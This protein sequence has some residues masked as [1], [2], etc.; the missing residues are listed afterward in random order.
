VIKIYQ[1]RMAAALTVAIQMLVIAGFIACIVVGPLDQPSP[2]ASP[3]DEIRNVGYRSASI[4]PAAYD[5]VVHQSGTWPV[6]PLPETGGSGSPGSG[7]ISFPVHPGPPI[8]A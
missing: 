7:L 4:S 5:V 6:D 2:I 3:D 8:P 1:Q